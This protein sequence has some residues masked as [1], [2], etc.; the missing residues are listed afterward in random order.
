[1]SVNLDYND[2]EVIWVTTAMPTPATTLVA[3][4]GAGQ[5]GSNHLKTKRENN[6][7][8]SAAMEDGIKT[9]A[10]DT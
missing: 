3:V 10:V 2:S 1:M 6:K 8:R 4:A 9:V 7:L 5:T